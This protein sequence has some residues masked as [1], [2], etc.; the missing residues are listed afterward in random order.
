MIQLDVLLPCQG[1]FST[2]GVPGEWGKFPKSIGGAGYS[3]K[4]L[5]TRG[6]SRI[7]TKPF[8]G[9][10]HNAYPELTD[11]GTSSRTSGHVKDPII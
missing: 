10:K 3:R 7:Q 9:D 6:S 11:G 4:N 2:A 5:S 8:E 1:T